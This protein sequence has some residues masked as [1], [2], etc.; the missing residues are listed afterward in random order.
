MRVPKIDACALRRYW[1]LLSH[2]LG[3]HRRGLGF[4]LGAALVSIALRL[5]LPLLIGVFIN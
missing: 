3:G 5:T 4:L 1:R 2:Y